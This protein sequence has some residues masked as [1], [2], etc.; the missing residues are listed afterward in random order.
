MV[1]G[2][3]TSERF[4]FSLVSLIR[5]LTF[6]SPGVTQGGLDF[7]QHLI[8]TSGSENYLT[9]APLMVDFRKNEK[10]NKLTKLFFFR[11]ISILYHLQCL[12]DLG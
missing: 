8:L 9:D 6:F 2:I 12:L 10:E 11:N 7:D 1:L 3:L 5:F 4:F